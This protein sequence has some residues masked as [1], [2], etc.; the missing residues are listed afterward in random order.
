MM[1]GK[2][3]TKQEVERLREM[4][5][6]NASLTEIAQALGRGPNSIQAKADA[7]GIFLKPWRPSPPK[8]RG[9]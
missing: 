2:P 1:A 4:A 8:R 3:W 5:R 9:F 7:E 6:E